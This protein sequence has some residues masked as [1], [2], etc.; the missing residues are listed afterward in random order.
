MPKVIIIGAT[1]GI[2]WALAIAYARHG[3]EVGITGRRNERL[4]ALG[5]VLPGKCYKKCFDVRHETAMQSLRELIAEMGTVDTI[6]VNAGMGHVNPSVDWEL[7]RT[8][9][10]TNVQGFAAMCSVAMHYFFLRG[11]GH[12][13]GVSSIAGIRGIGGAPAYTASK[14]FVSNY[15]ESLRGIVRRANAKIIVTD[16]QPGF[17]DTAMGQS[18]NAF[19]VASTEKAAEQIVDALRVGETHI[20][21]TKR[22][23]FIAWTLKV[24]PTWIVNRIGT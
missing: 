12:L 14:A 24:L 1:S 3:C 2:G 9:I 7:E 17:V 13:A 15:L 4:N 22:W 20:Y 11:K 16:I 23:R 18:K 21:V 10:E 6:V 19:W 5:E 8:C